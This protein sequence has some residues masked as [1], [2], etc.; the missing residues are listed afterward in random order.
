MPNISAVVLAGGKGSRM[1][2]LCQTRAKPV[3]P[4]AGAYRV[5]DFSLS[6]CVNS[7][8]SDI[9]ILVDHQRQCVSGYLENSSF[10]TKFQRP[11][12]ILEPVAGSYSGTANA[13][14]QNLGHIESV[15]S[16]A[17]LVLAGDHVYRM[18][19]RKMLAFHE[20]SGADV[21]IGVVPVPPGEASRFGIV[22]ADSQ[23][24][25]LE[26]VEKPLVPQGNLASMGIYIFNRSV[27]AL[28]LTEDSTRESS[29]H[30]FGRSIIPGM[31]N[32]F[33]VF[34]YQFTGYWQ[35]I[36][37]IDS[38][39]HA[40]LDLNRESAG[41][42]LNGNWPIISGDGQELVNA[43]T[44]PGVRN[45]RIG[46]G[47]EIQGTVENSILFPGVRVERQATIRN[48]IILGGTVVGWHTVIDRCI[49]DE[50]SSIGKSCFL[51]FSAGQR[52]EADGITVLGKGVEVPDYTAIGRNSRISAFATAAGFRTN[53]L[54]AGTVMCRQ[55]IAAS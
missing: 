50:G 38:Y 21:T 43:E 11:L 6:N 9:S 28:T 44:Q 33:N 25:I 19:Y 46:A 4:F 27:L 2:I 35:D 31:L 8:I 37:T 47:C 39:Y 16:D 14:F 52:C 1:D 20:Q 42:F 22:K 49:V 10:T 7:G 5:I 18:D 40:N 53:A 29:V 45:S 30:D 15:G 32:R 51:G 13:V 34:A 17:V 3:L 23:G 55:P 36:G 24:R 54:L 48:S 12:R 41:L 26:F